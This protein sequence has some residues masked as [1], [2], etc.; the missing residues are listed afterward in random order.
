MILGLLFPLENDNINK[1]YPSQNPE[2]SIDD[3]IPKNYSINN[4]P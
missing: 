3:N 4:T 2:S 1:L